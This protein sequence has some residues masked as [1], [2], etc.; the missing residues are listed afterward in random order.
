MRRKRNNNNAYANMESHQEAAS[1]DH[2]GNIQFLVKIY[3]DF[4]DMYMV[5]GI[6]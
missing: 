1:Q 3:F 6:F 4:K 2:S 5:L